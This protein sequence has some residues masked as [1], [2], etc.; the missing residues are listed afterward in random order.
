MVLA[1][2]MGMQ[3]FQTSSRMCYVLQEFSNAGVAGWSRLGFGMIAG[4]T[5]FEV[6]QSLNLTDAINAALPNG[7]A[8][9]LAA[10]VSVVS[11]CGFFLVSMS[12]GGGEAS[13]LAKALFWGLLVVNGMIS[14]SEFLLYGVAANLIT[15]AIGLFWSSGRLPWRYSHPFNAEPL[16]P[17]YGEKTTMRERYWNNDYEPV[18]QR[19]SVGSPRF[20]PSGY[21]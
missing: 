5:G 20:M 17:E 11:A 12:I 7:A 1:W 14:A 10:L 8:S 6:M 13:V 2:K 15:V 3:V 19:R 18:P 16:L 4:A 9:I 21:R